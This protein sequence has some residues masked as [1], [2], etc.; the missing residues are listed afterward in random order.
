MTP[1]GNSWCICSTGN[2]LVSRFVEKF[3]GPRSAFKSSTIIYIVTW[4][5]RSEKDC[6]SIFLI[7]N[8]WFQYFY[9][10]PCQNNWL[11]F[12]TAKAQWVPPFCA[13]FLSGSDRP[14]GLWTMAECTWPHAKRKVNCLSLAAEWKWGC[15]VHPIQESFHNFA[16]HLNSFWC[17]KSANFSKNSLF[18]P[19]C[20]I[21]I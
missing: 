12:C 13:G 14:F 5:N 20:R 15:I 16:K 6:L 18:L 7:S 1:N 3:H 2:A 11:F 9:I 8:Q 21:I 17:S 10:T 19:S 4:M